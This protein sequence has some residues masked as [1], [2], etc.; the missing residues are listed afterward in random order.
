MQPVEAVGVEVISHPVAPEA[1]AG[2]GPGVVALGAGPA[3]AQVGGLGREEGLHVVHR[4]LVVPP[5]VLGRALPKGQEYVGPHAGGK[6]AEDK[7][8]TM[9]V[10]SGL[11]AVGIERG[12]T[13]TT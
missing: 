8:K 1:L 9:R 5:A 4:Q 6:Q 2:R 12:R 11:N 7:T 10:H 3:H 13:T